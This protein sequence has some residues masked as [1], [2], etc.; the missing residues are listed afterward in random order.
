MKTHVDFYHGLLKNL[1]HSE[2]K[3]TDKMAIKALLSLRQ[4]SYG[5]SERILPTTILLL[6]HVFVTPAKEK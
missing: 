4:N 1:V 5:K 2:K 6:V 3:I